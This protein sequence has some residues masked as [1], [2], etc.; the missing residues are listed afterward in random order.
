M[1]LNSLP[2][3]TC[4]CLVQNLNRLGTPSRALVKAGLKLKGEEKLLPPNLA[5]VLLLLELTYKSREP[6]SISECGDQFH[7]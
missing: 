7:L 1:T 2:S 4:T 6:Y 3:L 5:R